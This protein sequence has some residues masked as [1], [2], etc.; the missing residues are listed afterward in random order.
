MNID[1]LYDYPLYR[2]PSEGL[3]LIIQATLGCSHNKC[4]FC[5]MYKGKQFTIKSLEEIK[6][7][8][9]IFG[10]MYGH[11]NGIRIFLA[12]GDALIIPMEKLREIMVYLNE[13]FPKLDRISMYASPKSIRL[14]TPEELKEL[15]SL[16]L[17][18]IYLGVESGSDKVLKFIKKGVTKAEMLEAGLKAK[19]A[20]IK[21]SV[22][23]I[24]GVAQKSGSEEH[25]LETADIIS[26][27][28]PDFFS[29]LT[30]RIYEGT[31]LYEEYKKGNFVRMSDADLLR[32]VK[33]II[34]NINVKEPCVFRSNH[35]SNYLPLGGTLPQDK[36]R[37]AAVIDTVIKNNKELENQYTTRG[38]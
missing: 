29:I 13:K 19:A 26:K 10:R 14:K 18:L 16:G 4:T 20:G 25:A 31:E 15:H 38:M 6:R 11:I 30:M 1:D 2:P 28:N 32:E 5:N 36:E 27:M 22:T 17:K 8:I 23:V 37:I 3:N 7:E 33:M 12:D 24:T 21:I 9:D 35:A 34:E